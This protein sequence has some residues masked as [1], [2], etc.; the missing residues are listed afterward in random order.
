MWDV[1]QA[2][3]STTDHRVASVGFVSVNGLD[4]IVASAGPEGVLAALQAVTTTVSEVTT[5]L[6]VDWLDV[7]VGIDSVKL[8]LAAGAPRAIDHDEDRLLLAL[9]RIVDECPVSLRGG[10]AT[11]EG[12][13]R[14]ARHRGA[15]YLHRAR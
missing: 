7:D 1:L 11:G 3:A 12:V 9:R 2:D 10:C 15:S 8:M 14:T 6:G 4:A 5:E 13:R